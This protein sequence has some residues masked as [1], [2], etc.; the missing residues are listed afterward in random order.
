MTIYSRSSLQNFDNLWFWIKKKKNALLNL[1]N[2][3]NDIDKIYLFS[4][5][6]SGAKYKFLIKKGKNAVIK[7]L[8]DPNAF[9]ECFNTMDDVY[10]NIDNYNPRRKTNLCVCVFD[11]TIADMMTN[12]NFKP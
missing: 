8:N 6:L 11:H 7:Y 1:V 5:D 10:E 2:E 12:K 9:I 3:Q 4:K